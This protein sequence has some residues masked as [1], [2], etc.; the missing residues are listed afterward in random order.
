MKYTLKSGVT[1]EGTL[2]QI[3]ATAKKLGEKVNVGTLG[4]L[5]KGYYL[6]DTR[7]VIKIADMETVHIKNSLLKRTK[8]YYEALSK[9][10]GLANPAFVK[11]FTSLVEDEQVQ[12]LFAELVK[13]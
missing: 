1:V 12:E 6:S 9:E 2:E 13:R 4:K 11:K 3:M 8:S 10:K 5:P 7:G